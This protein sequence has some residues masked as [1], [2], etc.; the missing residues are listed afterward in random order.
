MKK[1]VIGIIFML[2]IPAIAIN[3]NT[4]HDFSIIE[5]DGKTL[6]VGGDG[7]GNYTRIQDA[8]DNASDGDTIFVYDDSSPYY[9]SIFINKSIKLVGENRETTIIESPPDKWKAVD[10][11]AANVTINGFTIRGMYDGW[12]GINIYSNGNKIINN[13]IERNTYGIVIKNSNNL[14][15][16]NI[17]AKQRR[18]GINI[19][20]GSNNKIVNNIF[21]DNHIGIYLSSSGNTISNNS[22]LGGAILVFSFPNRIVNNTVNKLPLLYLENA[23]NIIIDEK[24]GQII[25]AN[26]NN[27]TVR[28]QNISHTYC[29]IQ[30]FKTKNCKICSNNLWLCDYGIY[31]QNSSMNNITKN[32]IYT[33]ISGICM[34]NTRFNTIFDNDISSPYKINAYLT[35]GIEFYGFS[36]NNS[37]IKNRI[38]ENY[39]GVTS[40]SLNFECNKF[41]NNIIEN[42]ENGLGI[43]GFGNII[44]NNILKNDFIDL[45][46]GGNNNKILNNTFLGKGIDVWEGIHIIKNNTLKDKPILAFSNEKNKNIKGDAGQVIL[47][48]CQ[49]FLIENI[50]FLHA[51]CPIQ[52]LYTS[53][54]TVRN[55]KFYIPGAYTSISIYKSTN[56]TLLNNEIFGWNYA[57]IYLKSSNDNLVAYNLLENIGNGIVIESSK[58]NKIVSNE[59]ND[60]TWDGIA[61][62]RG[63]F[64]V[65]SGNVI[66][67]SKES[68]IIMEE[69]VFNVISGNNLISNKIGIEMDIIAL[70]NVI[71]N[72]NFID[73]ERNA[74]FIDAYFTIWLRN[75]W[76]NWRLPL[77]KPI[78]GFHGIFP[79]CLLGY[80]WLNFDLMPRMFPYKPN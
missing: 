16:F 1:V 44:S 8:I 73:N 34:K 51:N 71:L 79:G 7:P 63:A 40:F 30:L 9:E 21:L 37:I 12:I 52:L 68:G 29:G 75:Y 33:K 43:G 17:I 32:S 45:S 55:C 39:D 50:T 5:E 77:P 23:T 3:E 47:M 69:A 66:S 2:F 62:G 58:K 27:I 80:P 26:C 70:F 14:I 42:N 53:F 20:N 6:Y 28:N 49:N 24:A 46:I 19:E 11:I 59:I 65:L 57:G 25:L 72:N 38:R 22:F 15:A 36:S 54:T 61:I 76:D 48:G 31:L 13:K 78:F 41:L 4:D 10:I 60:T 35:S 18:H 67:N 64:N 74:F 56:N